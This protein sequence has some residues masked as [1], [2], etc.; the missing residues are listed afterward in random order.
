M[1]ED[2]LEFRGPP[3]GELVAMDIAFVIDGAYA[4]FFSTMLSRGTIHGIAALEL[5][6]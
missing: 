5:H 3:A 2:F 6:P 1:E 4:T